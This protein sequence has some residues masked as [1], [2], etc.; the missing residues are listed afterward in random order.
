M[1]HI[2]PPFTSFSPS[3]PIDSF[4]DRRFGNATSGKQQ[5]SKTNQ[6]PS[7]GSGS[8]QVANFA[9]QIRII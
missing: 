2:P 6:L 9:T 1:V 8:R 4:V 3:H 5:K 7:L